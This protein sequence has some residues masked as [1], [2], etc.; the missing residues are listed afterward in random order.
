MWKGVQGSREKGVIVE[1][2]RQKQCFCF[3]LH[4]IRESYYSPD[5]LKPRRDQSKQ[6]K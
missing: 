1:F 4:Q 2:L 5:L 3:P 6:Q